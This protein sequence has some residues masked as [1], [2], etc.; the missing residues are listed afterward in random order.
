MGCIVPITRT[1]YL[2]LIQGDVPRSPLAHIPDYWTVEGVY[3]LTMAECEAAGREAQAQ[4]QT[5]A[6]RS[7]EIMQRLLPRLIAQDAVLK[8]K[9]GA[10]LR[11]AE[12]ARLLKLAKKRA[13]KGG[14]GSGCFSCGQEGQRAVDCP[15]AAHTGSAAP[16]PA[17]AAYAVPRNAEP[18]RPGAGGAC[19]KCGGMGHRAVDCP[20]RPA[21]PPYSFLAEMKARRESR[22]GRRPLPQPAL[23]TH[24][25]LSPPAAG[26]A[27]MDAWEEEGEEEDSQ[28]EKR[29]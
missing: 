24:C 16:R 9:E 12:E 19:F 7:A 23:L 22:G 17:P 1:F 26:D 29:R 20:E 11:A 14:R 3:D 8:E 27:W 4:A 18:G 25:H 6:K 15:A 5:G 13:K 21:A 28:P 10:L 2:E